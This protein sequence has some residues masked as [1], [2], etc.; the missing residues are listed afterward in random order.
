MHS[1]CGFI[2]FF[3]SLQTSGEDWFKKLESSRMVC[4]VCVPVRCLPGL[5]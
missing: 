5:T 3:C 1:L 2:F 4:C